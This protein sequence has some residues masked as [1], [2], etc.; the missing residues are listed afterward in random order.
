MSEPDNLF[1]FA[2]EED[3]PIP[4]L[5]RI[6]EYY[7]GLG[8]GAPYRWAHYAQVPFTP[9]RKPL[10]ESRVALITTAAPYKPGAGDHGAGAAYN[11][12]AK[13]F[14][15]YSGDTAIDHDLGISHIAYDRVHTSAA[16]GNCWFPLPAMRRMAERGVI[17]EVAPRFHGAPTNRSHRTTLNKDCPELLR[18]VV[19]DKADVAVLLAV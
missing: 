1:G 11:G 16:D 8:Y 10:S 3:V 13:F 2:P 19:E 15:V 14:D 12:A 4:Y 9:L 5:T 6:R 18:R 7:Q 17:G